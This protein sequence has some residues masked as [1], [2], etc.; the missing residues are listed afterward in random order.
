MRVRP[1]R[2][3]STLKIPANG[4]APTQ[5]GI[6]IQR[7]NLQVLERMVTK[8]SATK[9]QNA[10]WSVSLHGVQNFAPTHIRFVGTTRLPFGQS[11]SNVS[12][13]LATWNLR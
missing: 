5:L 7:E 12:G 1:W 9:T 3:G 6:G 4:S 10:V 2:S 8:S 13:P 11:M